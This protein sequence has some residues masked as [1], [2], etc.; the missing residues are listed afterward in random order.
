MA[1]NLAGT[2]VLAK[3]GAWVRMVIYDDNNDQF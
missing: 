1:K 2:V 3:M